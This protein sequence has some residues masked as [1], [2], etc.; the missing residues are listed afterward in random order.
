MS[1]LWYNDFFCHL[2]CTK[3]AASA[4]AC[5]YAGAANHNI[6]TTYSTTASVYT[7]CTACTI[8]PGLYATACEARDAGVYAATDATKACTTG[9]YATNSHKTGEAACTTGVLCSIAVYTV[10][11]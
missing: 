2:K 5:S 7:A 3:C 6:C 11:A 9:I 10:G 1:A 8:N 4:P